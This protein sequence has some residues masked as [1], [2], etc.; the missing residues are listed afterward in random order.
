M[1]QTAISIEQQKFDAGAARV[2]MKLEVAARRR[3]RYGERLSCRPV[4]APGFRGLD[5]VRQ[6]SHGG[7][8]WLYPGWADTQGRI[9]RCER[10]SACNKWHLWF[11]VKETT[12]K[13]TRNSKE[14]K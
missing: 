8:A 5:L 2:D 10:L 13:E 9:C 1:S 6:G 11:S 12:S 14:K 4:H 7:R 3:H